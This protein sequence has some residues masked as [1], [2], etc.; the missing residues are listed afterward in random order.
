VSQLLPCVRNT[1]PAGR[2]AAAAAVA[3][4]Q[5]LK[6]EIKHTLQNK[7]HRNAGPEDLVA[8]EAMLN[9]ILGKYEEEI[10]GPWIVMTCFRA[11]GQIWGLQQLTTT[12]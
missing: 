2:S 8:A 12:G 11:C 3:P 9:R 7:L 10:Q 4:L 6:Q 5:D 1:L